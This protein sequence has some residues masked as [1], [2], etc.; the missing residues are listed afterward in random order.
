M[1]FKLAINNKQNSIFS[2]TVFDAFEFKKISGQ[3]KG[4]TDICVYRDDETMLEVTTETVSYGDVKRQVNKV[5]NCSDRTY[6]INKF[7]SLYMDGIG[8]FDTDNEIYVHYCKN[9]WQGEGQWGCS[10]LDDLGVYHV[11]AHAWAYQKTVFSSVGPQSTSTYYPLVIIEDKKLNKFWYFE[12][13]GAVNWDIEIGGANHSVTSAGALF[14]D[15][16]CANT[17]KDG[18]VY[19]LKPG[20]E[21]TASPAVYGESTSFENAIWDVLEYKRAV[22]HRIEKDVPICF[23]NYMNCIWERVTAEKLV[24]LIDKAAE[25]GCEI[26]CIDDGWFVRGAENCDFGDWIW[27][28]R[29]FG[30]YGFKGIIEYIR[31]KNMIPGIWLEIER[32]GAN[33]AINR[34]S[35]SALLNRNGMV[36]GKDN[37]SIN[38]SDSAVREYLH[39]V[40]DKLYNL[41]IRYIKND[42]NVPYGIG[43]DNY[44]HSSSYG[45]QQNTYAFYS[46][47]DEVKKKYPDLIIENCGSGALRSDNGTLKRF[48]LQS[49]SDQERYYYWP[50]I[51]KGTLACMPPEKMGIWSM[52][53]PHLYYDRD[54]GSIFDSE[55]YIKRMSDGEETVFNMI[56]SMFGLM[57]LSGRIDKCDEYNTALVKAGTEL[58]KKIRNYIPGS[59]PL[60][61]D[62]MFKMNSKGL[63]SIALL[64]ETEKV[65]MMGMFSVNSDKCEY[66]VDISE[67]V[68]DNARLEYVYPSA[69]KEIELKN[70]IVTALL[71]KDNCAR[72]CV[73]K[74]D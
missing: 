67:Y 33:A 13:E 48:D 38:F 31:S 25:V 70:G 14:V 56:N 58:Y 65:L 46:F 26:F 74:Y 32:S 51:I 41:G 28:D 66:A 36:I 43:C 1:N 4:N 52:P 72:Y 55:D 71:N 63:Y 15:V 54:N 59:K 47:I 2:S 50:S 12:H 16:C 64:N 57:T 7:S 44:G 37:C 27:D 68:G 6:I 5:K 21:Y 34:I 45:L 39:S 20:D 29:N 9:T 23:N 73:V 30:D 61:L 49:V 53:Y 19:T 11:A 10:K 3:T 24:P 18:F 17:Q 69:C 62:G 35:E 40:F 42:Y 22:S 60:F 8:Q